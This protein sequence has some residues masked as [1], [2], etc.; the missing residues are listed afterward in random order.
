MEW[1][2]MV[3]LRA[4]NL[5]EKGIVKEWL[6]EGDIIQNGDQFALV[7][8]E[9]G[10]D[11][12][13][14]SHLDGAVVKTVK[15]G[16][17]VKNGSVLAN[18]A[19]GSK[20]IAKFKNRAYQEGEGPAVA[21]LDDIEV[22]EDAFQRLASA[23]DALDEIS[24]AVMYDRNYQAP[25]PFSSDD[26][27]MDT[28]QKYKAIL[29]RDE[30]MKQEQENA[31][32]K[33]ATMK[34]RFSQMRA[35]IAASIK[36][37]PNAK[38]LE[39]SEEDKQ[40][41]AAMSNEEAMKDGNLFST[42]NGAG[43]SKFRQLI[44]SRKEK[45]LEEN[46]FQEVKDEDLQIDAMSKLD[47]KGRPLIMRNIIANRL[48]KFNKA[49]G[50]PAAIE[51][52]VVATKDNAAKNYK[53]QPQEILMDG[54]AKYIK[55][56]DNRFEGA[57]Q[58]DKSKIANT[59]NGSS[60]FA[61]Q[62]ASEDG[63]FRVSYGAY[64]DDG[65]NME[66]D[67][68]EITNTGNTFLPTKDSKTLLNEIKQKSDRTYAE[69]KIANLYDS[70]R[71]WE[72]IKSRND[73]SE[74][75]K[76]RHLM[77]EGKIVDE[78][79]LQKVSE[80]KI[81]DVEIP[82]NFLK[83]SII[84]TDSGKID[85]VKYKD[86]PQGREEFDNWLRSANLYA[87]YRDAEEDPSLRV[88]NSTAAPKNISSISGDSKNNSPATETDSSTIDFLK[89]QV[90]EL[91]GQLESKN[92]MK[93][94][95]N[96]LKTGS[97]DFE[98]GQSFTEMMQLMMMQQLM[99]NQNNSQMDIKKIIQD[100]LDEFKSS[101]VNDN[102]LRRNNED[103]NYVNTKRDIANLNREQITPY[104]KP[105]EAESNVLKRE[106]LSATALP[107]VKSMILSQNLIPPLT[108]STEVDMTSI[109][110]LK[111]VLKKTDP[112]TLYSTILFITKALSIA[113]AEYPKLNSSYDPETNELIVKAYHNIGLATE[114]SE[115]LIIPVLKFVEKLSL[116]ELAIDIQEM[117]TR[118]RR[119]ELYNY[120]TSG[121]TIT[122][123]NYGNIGAIQA[124]PTI[125][126]PNAAVVGVGKVIK[127][128]VVVD[129]EKLAI[130]AMMNVSL[131][132]DQRIIDNA[133]AGRF[134]ARMKEI[135]EK[136]ELITVS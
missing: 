92:Q 82:A 74:I 77:E 32:Q 44:Q 22:H 47:E 34:D 132:V 6:F 35:N 36:N 45:L 76:R 115:G 118:L 103:L 17:P 51:N 10:Q 30:E 21:E 125:F 1:L 94:A 85:Y 71:R 90:E 33:P 3:H 93:S 48:E 41:L 70:N 81:G 13:V 129:N 104:E 4:K 119:G 37:N 67:L 31:Q 28:P 54:E 5:P 7:E 9:S 108:I 69:S 66:I 73:I 68:N 105:Q 18:I 133:T 80:T 136:P 88:E 101:L 64:V 95:Q 87:A 84:Q 113:L 102:R 121:S 100:Q 131:T 19:V 52:E 106:S 96:K 127:K 124:T 112:N 26:K 11:V 42:E 83:E 16:S 29:K 111:H 114:T 123:A 27:L 126:F 116:R 39:L 117:T 98:P 56:E 99:Q 14:K 78:S 72:I 79:H 65:E 109:L 25:T 50:D 15:I 61:R 128:P 75:N 38:N 62:V 23:D 55:E 107:A 12:I 43:V 49:G 46:D 97:F 134:L 20:E 63:D 86:T 135:L 8:T 91:Q 57:H 89:Q 122:L 24:G 58:V 53:P 2:G 130:K 120:E 60:P 110:K 59:D 40:K